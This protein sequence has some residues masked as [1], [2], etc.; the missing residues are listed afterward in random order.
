M[1][2][3]IKTSRVYDGSQLSPGG[4]PKDP[5]TPECRHEWGGHWATKGERQRL[6]RRCRRWIWD[7]DWRVDTEETP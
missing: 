6:C 3:W 2:E 7:H 5:R 4:K 1:D